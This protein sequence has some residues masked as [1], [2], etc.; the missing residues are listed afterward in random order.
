MDRNELKRRV[1]VGDRDY[2]IFDINEL[3]RRGLAE[4]RGLPFSIKILVENLLRKLDGRV[5]REEDLMRVA[6]WKKSYDVPVEIPY[7]PSRVLMQDF[8]GGP[9]V[10][11][12]AAMRDAM[13]DLGG[14]PRMI[15]PLV[16]VDLVVDHSVQVVH[17]GTVKAL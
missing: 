14:D 7:H 2:T 9:A 12:L 11:D 16:R 13:R 4:I 1:V 10:V 5:V 17:F 8:T 3:E 6:R 15:N